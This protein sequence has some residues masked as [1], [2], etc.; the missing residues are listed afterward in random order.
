MNNLVRIGT[1][2]S[3]LAL[4]QARQ[5][6]NMLGIVGLR[7]ELVPI[8]SSGD[9]A[10]QKPLYEMGVQGI[11]T[12]E[13]DAALL[14][15]QIDVAVHSMKD[16]PIQLPKGITTA[17]IPKRGPVADVF[18]FKNEAWEVNKSVVATSSL[19]RAAQWMHKYPHHSII[20]IRGN[21]PTR[22]KKLERLDC[23]GTIMAIA[24]LK[25]LEILPK[26]NAVLDW[27]VPAP[28]Q[29]ALLVTALESSVDLLT[30][31]SPLN[32]DETALCVE[33]ER[34]FLRELEGGCTA[35][36]G[37]LARIEGDQIHFV[38]NITQKGGKEQR[39]FDQYLPI[40]NA[41]DIGAVAAKKLLS[42]DA[43]ALLN[44]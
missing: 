14:E 22:L 13:L 5:A 40:E 44:G 23:E 41:H 17:F 35:P 7:S 19:R 8:S 28:A 12:K 38:G 43:K 1:R 27:M 30:K 26:R 21:V 20:D 10:L 42:Q 31:L 9:K 32:D 18:I 3:A 6:Q 34:I 37:A 29:G 36:I 11:F 2:G 15:G 25:R 39:V 24:G 33:Q 4:W 16:V